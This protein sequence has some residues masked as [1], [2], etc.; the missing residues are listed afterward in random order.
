MVWWDSIYLIYLYSRLFC[1]NNTGQ[2]FGKRLLGLSAKL[3]RYTLL[4]ICLMGP[5][6]L[7]YYII[8]LWVGNHDDTFFTWPVYS[9]NRRWVFCICSYSLQY[10]LIY[11]NK[12][13]VMWKASMREH[14]GNLVKFLHRCNSNCNFELPCSSG[15]PGVSRVKSLLYTV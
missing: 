12:L 4:G 13:I 3:A 5:G 14:K 6:S 11:K 8:L 2:Q 9:T 1:F 7:L 10:M 15:I